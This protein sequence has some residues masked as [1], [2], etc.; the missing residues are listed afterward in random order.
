M[1]LMEPKVIQ[2]QAYHWEHPNGTHVWWN[3]TRAKELVSNR[4]PDNVMP[5]ES[6]Y[7]ALTRNRFAREL[8][9]DYAIGRDLTV[10]LIATVAPVLDGAPEGSRPM[11]II[12]GWHRI[13]GAVLTYHTQ[14]LPVHILTPEEDAACRFNPENILR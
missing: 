3:I 13:V 5:I 14:P 6:A 9:Q 11:I 7:E 1:M 12:D 2:C 4:P 8:D 10:P